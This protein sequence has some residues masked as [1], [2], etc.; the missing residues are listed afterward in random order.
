MLSLNVIRR[1]CIVCVCIYAVACPIVCI[2]NCAFNFNN[3]FMANYS[4]KL[5]NVLFY[6]VWTWGHCNFLALPCLFCFSSAH[7]SQLAAHPAAILYGW[8]FIFANNYTPRLEILLHSFRFYCF[9]YAIQCI[10][11]FLLFH[12]HVLCFILLLSIAIFICPLRCVFNFNANSI[13]IFK[14]NTFKLHSKSGNKKI[15]LP[16]IR[17]SL[18][19]HLLVRL[20]LCYKIFFRA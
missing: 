4:H 16:R 5:T 9:L 17:H 1:Y 6:F 3:L 10:A 12:L 13:L 11:C 7:V 20:L 14:L 8:H 19:T 18:V 15:C 2:I